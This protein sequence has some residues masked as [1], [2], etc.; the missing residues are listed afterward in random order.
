MT[1]ENRFVAIAS[2]S[3][4]AV[5]LEVLLKY[6]T[7]DEQS[8]LERLGSRTELCNPEKNWVTGPYFT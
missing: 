4:C 8:A 6:C 3:K 1:P 5:V 2:W 7:K